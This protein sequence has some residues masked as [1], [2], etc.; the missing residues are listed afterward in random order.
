MGVFRGIRPIHVRS[1]I[2][3]F[4]HEDASVVAN[5]RYTVKLSNISVDS[6]ARL[7][8]NSRPINT[9]KDVMFVFPEFMMGY[10]YPS[11]AFLSAGREL[12]VQPAIWSLLSD[13]ERKEIIVN[14][15]ESSP[16]LEFKAYR[17]LTKG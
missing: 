13:E 11:S 17:E 7:L 2:K 6:E 5:D 9:I 14:I 16:V 4:E 8:Y 10:G 12:R 15:N 1:Y 3:E